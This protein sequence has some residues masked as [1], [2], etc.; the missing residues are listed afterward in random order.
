MAST[1]TESADL[2][3]SDPVDKRIRSRYSVLDKDKEELIFHGDSVTPGLAD[4][5]PPS[6]A[7]K[8]HQEQQ[9]RKQILLS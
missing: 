2:P 6:R 5:T 9:V 4:S 8:G 3:A 7:E 1:L